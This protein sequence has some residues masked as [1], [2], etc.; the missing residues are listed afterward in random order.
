MV[1][2]ERLCVGGVHDAVD[3]PIRGP[4]RQQ[5]HAVLV[6]AAAQGFPLHVVLDRT[7]WAASS[8]A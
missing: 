4:V 7:W 3:H 5:L 2:T 8:T 6:D 1:P